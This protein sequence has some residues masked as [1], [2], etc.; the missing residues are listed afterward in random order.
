MKPANF[1]QKGGHTAWKL[2]AKSHH[3]WQ[4]IKA[5]RYTATTAIAKW[6]CSHLLYENSTK[7]ASD[8]AWSNSDLHKWLIVFRE[9]GNCFKFWTV[10]PAGV[11]IHS[12]QW[13]HLLRLAVC[14]HMWWRSPA[15]T[16]LNYFVQVHCR[17]RCQPWRALTTRVTSQPGFKRHLTN[18]AQSQWR[19]TASG[20]WR[21][22]L[23]LSEWTAAS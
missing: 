5:I 1:S 10:Q 18:V 8:I 16:S 3:K 23:R 9:D 22:Q 11:P 14:Q 7:N 15:M 21:H 19:N 12:T 6:I 20:L 4:I 13:R 2:I 17:K